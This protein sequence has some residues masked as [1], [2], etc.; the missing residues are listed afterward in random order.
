[1][2]SNEKRSDR[3]VSARTIYAAIPLYFSIPCVFRKYVGEIYEL[4]YY[5]HPPILSLSSFFLLLFPFFIFH[6]TVY[7]LSSMRPIC[8]FIKIYSYEILF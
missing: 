7:Q 5:H 1:M 3:Y 4:E 6:F 2:M 8:H